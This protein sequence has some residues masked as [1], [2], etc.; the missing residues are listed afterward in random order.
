[1]QISWNKRTFL[2]E[3]RVVAEEMHSVQASCA[4]VLLARHAILH[5]VKQERV[6]NP[7]ER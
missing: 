7:Q 5:N 2:R 3:K 6:T 1:M 4:G